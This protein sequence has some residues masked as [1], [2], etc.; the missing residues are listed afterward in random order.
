M[1]KW[2]A[3]L[4]GTDLRALMTLGALTM[5]VSVPLVW[6]IQGRISGMPTAPSVMVLTYTVC[7][8]PAGA[9]TK[10]ISTR[11][12]SGGVYA[13]CKAPV[14]SLVSGGVYDISAT[15]YCCIPEDIGS[16]ATVPGYRARGQ[17]SGCRL[18][19]HLKRRPRHSNCPCQA[20]HR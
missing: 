9:G 20:G 8:S 12:V 14:M 7:A 16:P 17:Y 5:E 19:E 2:F 4:T 18:A 3:P 10:S 6:A 13:G 15:L 11:R 1:F